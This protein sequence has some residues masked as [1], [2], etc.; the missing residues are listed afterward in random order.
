MI[1]DVPH[2]FAI[3]PLPDNEGGGYLI[4]FP[5]LPGCMSDGERVEEAIANGLDVMRGWSAA[6]RAEGIRSP[7]RPAPR[8]HEPLAGGPSMAPTADL[9]LGGQN[10]KS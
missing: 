7:D 1:P 4:E 6:M 9:H 3:R 10:G 5:D 8:R 2:R